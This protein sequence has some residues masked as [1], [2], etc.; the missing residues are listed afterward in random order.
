M[1]LTDHCS[2]ECV[3][4]LC[5]AMC[6]LFFHLRHS[7]HIMDVLVSLVAHSRANTD[8]SRSLCCHDR[9]PWQCTTVPVAITSVAKLHGRRALHCACTS[10][11]VVPSVQQSLFWLWSISGCHS[12]HLEHFARIRR[13]RTSNIQTSFETVFVDLGICCMQ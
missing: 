1:C 6:L 10:L 8:S 12:S 4:E 9:S 5:I 2:S 3:N 11:L 7:N 13:Y